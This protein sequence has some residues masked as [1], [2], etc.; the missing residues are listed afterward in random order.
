M[1]FTN[2]INPALLSLVPALYFLGYALKRSKTPDKHI[3]MILACAGTLLALVW[4][5]SQ[6]IVNVFAAAFTAIVQGILCA[7]AS[8]LANQIIKQGSKSK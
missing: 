5:L 6:P 1:D 8:V 7:G 4:V 3:P 2:Y